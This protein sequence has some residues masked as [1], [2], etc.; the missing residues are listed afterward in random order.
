MA[1]HN[2]KKISI[3]FVVDGRRLE[4]QSVLLVASLFRHHQDD[5][6]VELVAYVTPQTIE[7]LDPITRSVYEKCRVEIVP[8]SV[9][10]DVWKKPYP[11]GNKLLACAFRRNSQATIFVDTDMVCLAPLSDLDLSGDKSVLAVPEGVPT[12]GKNDD[13]WPRAYAFF[14]LPVPTDRVTLTRGKR[15]KFYPYFNAGFVAFSNREV[16]MGQTLGELWLATAVEFDWGCAI[17]QKRPWL[18]QITLPLTLKRFGL[19]YQVLP[20]KYNFSISVRKGIRQ[21]DDCKMMHYHRGVFLAETTQYGDVVSDAFALAGTSGR[22]ALSQLLSDG[23][24]PRIDAP[25]GQPEH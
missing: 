5:P 19:E 15:I 8:L 25:S 20:D 21:T 13:R 16:A 1:T 6:L 18:D 14:G 12:W 23:S 17:G 24:F 10:R 2:Q 3:I 4:A 22:D 7:N 9:S 11:H